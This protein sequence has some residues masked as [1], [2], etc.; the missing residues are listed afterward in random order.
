MANYPSSLA[1]ASL[2]QYA[3]RGQSEPSLRSRDV[4]YKVKQ[5]G[6]VGRI[7][8]IEFATERLVQSMGTHPFLSDYFNGVTTL[9]PVPRSS[10]LVKPDALWPPL[11]ICQAILAQ[12]GLAADILPCL[13]RTRAVRKSATAPAS[14]RPSP[15]E[16]YNSVGVTHT[17]RPAPKAITL[18]DDVVT[19]GSSFIGI[20]PHLWDA[21]PGIAIRCFALVRTISRGDIDQILDPVQGIITYNGSDLLRQP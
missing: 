12:P 17:Q 3:P 19:R 15:V 13:E 14:G 11:R 8:I 1:F 10:P 21:F 2:L 6:Y 18:I 20:V 9:I 5:D 16:H 4:T 7:R